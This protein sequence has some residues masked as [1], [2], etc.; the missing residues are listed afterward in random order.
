MEELRTPSL[1]LDAK[2][3]ILS[4]PAGSKP[5]PQQ[6][7]PSSVSRSSKKTPRQ[8]NSSKKTKSKHEI[9]PVAISTPRAPEDP[10]PEPQILPVS[11]AKMTPQVAALQHQMMDSDRKWNS[12]MDATP[13]KKQ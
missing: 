12:V 4:T 1:P 6:R 11:K 5:N 8:P 9:P 13:Q 7:R 3:P 10:I 2:S